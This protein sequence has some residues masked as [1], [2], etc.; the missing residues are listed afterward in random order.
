MPRPAGERGAPTGV[1]GGLGGQRPP[2]PRCSQPR[3]RERLPSN[4]RPLHRQ[5]TPEES[6]L[7]YVLILLVG[8]CVGRYVRFGVRFLRLDAVCHVWEGWE[9]S[10]VAGCWGT[11][12]D[13]HSVL[14]CGL[15]CD[16]RFFNG[17]E[18]FQERYLSFAFFFFGF[19]FRAPLRGFVP[20]SVSLCALWLDG[21]R[22][23]LRVFSY[24]LRVHCL[25]RK[26]R[27]H[28]APPGNPV[29]THFFCQRASLRSGKHERPVP[30]YLVRPPLRAPCG[31][32]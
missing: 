15:R 16:A 25:P 32:P 17:W 28:A 21:F 10:S 18:T 3:H 31:A 29:W 19:A 27:V 4:I 20:N 11:V 5:G 6:P 13:V 2:P 14:V 30:L 22:L 9:G 8:G 1:R 26:R 24:C 23:K 12:P 7:H